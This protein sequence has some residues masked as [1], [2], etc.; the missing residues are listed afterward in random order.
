[1]KIEC[2]KYICYLPL[3]FYHSCGREDA[4]V[5]QHAMRM[6]HIVICGLFDSSIFFQTIIIILKIIIILMNG[7]VF[8]GLIVEL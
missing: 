2:M 8:V 3:S 7:T 1:M 5:T 4:L 6:H